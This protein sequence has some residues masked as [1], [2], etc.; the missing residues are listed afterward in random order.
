MQVGWADRLHW[1]L[2]GFGKVV[3]VKKVLLCPIRCLS[4]LNRNQA[5]TKS[6]GSLWL[7]RTLHTL[8]QRGWENSEDGEMTVV[9]AIISTTYFDIDYLLISDIVNTIVSIILGL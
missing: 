8:L 5:L 2:R 9:N 1:E 3:T 4:H 7:M 6:C